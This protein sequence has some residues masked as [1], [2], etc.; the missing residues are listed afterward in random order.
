MKV[1]EGEG[2]GK[3]ERTHETNKTNNNESEEE[4]KQ[5]RKD[6]EKFL[7]DLE[8]YN[9]QN[10]TINHVTNTQPV[11]QEEE[12]NVTNTTPAQ[13]VTRKENHDVMN[14]KVDNDIS[15][16]FEE[17]RK[18]TNINWVKDKHPFD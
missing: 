9:N 5:K 18:Q 17:L 4:R 8:K 16:N 12:D 2:V 1:N 10:N 7:R 11:P 13:V 14:D 6:N 15:K 3:V